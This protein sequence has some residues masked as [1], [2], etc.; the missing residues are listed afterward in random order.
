MSQNGAQTLRL[1]RPDTSAP[2]KQPAPARHTGILQDQLRRSARRPWSPSWTMAIRILLLFRFT[3]AMYS[4]ID[5]CDEVYNFWEPLH[6][7]DR[8]T[9]FQTW[10]TSPKYAIRSWAYILLHLLPARA[11][12]LVFKGADKRAAFFAVRIVYALASTL[13]EAT[14]YRTV[15]E[16]IN[17]RLSFP[18]TFAMHASTLAFSYAFVPSSLQNN[19]RVLLATICFAVG[20]VVGWPFAL[21][22]A[23]PFVI[24]ELFVAS[25]DRVTSDSWLSWIQRRWKRLATT[26]IIAST[27]FVPVIGID[28]LAYGRLTVYNIFGGADRGPDLYGT[29]PWYFYVLNLTLNFNVLVPLAF[30][31]LPALAVTYVV[32][33][34]RLGAYS[35]SSGQSSPFTVLGLRLAPLYVWAGILTLQPHKEERF[36]F[37][38]YPLVCFNAAEVVFVSVTKSPYKASQST[39]FRTFTLSVGVTAG[40]ISLSRIIALGQYY[41]TPLTVMHHFS[42]HEVVNLLNTTHLIPP[43]LPKTA[44]EDQP[45][46]DITPIK[47]FNLTLCVAK[48][49]HRF[50]GHYLVPDGVRVGFVKSEFS[51]LLPGKFVLPH[52]SHSSLSLWPWPGT[53]LVPV[54]QNDLNREEPSHYTSITDCD[55]L[56]D[57]DFP[58]RPKESSHEPRY[59]VQSAV[60]ERVACRP[61]LDGA[62]SQLLNLNEFGDYC[63]L[64]NKH[65]VEKKAEWVKKNV[66]FETLSESKSGM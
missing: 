23:I 45:R 10:E 2:T 19:R 63:L 44:P 31:A 28:S 9:G 53:H 40:I 49:W 20:G 18:S 54:D 27:I 14:F 8:G 25:S 17:E 57:L 34:K 46:V 24:E 32:D 16:R 62:H 39:L 35:P 51:G 52:S 65:R 36:M 61:F 29:E 1:R 15:H 11:A 21:A 43:P 50:P 6:F 48:E 56:V 4:N 12:G 55:Y 37:P 3:A 41:H 38:A 64:R 58:L 30:G 5:D 66:S 13:V 60:W 47:V 42:S 59:A 33:R 26:G 7:L 22:L